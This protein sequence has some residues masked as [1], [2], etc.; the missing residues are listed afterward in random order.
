MVEDTLADARFAENPLVTGFP[1]IRSYMGC[2]LIAEDG[3]RLGTLWVAP[4]REDA[5]FTC[6]ACSQPCANGRVCVPEPSGLDAQACA[7]GRGKACT[8]PAR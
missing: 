2:P 1:F 8:R 6:L 7:D 4:G 5:G 3:A